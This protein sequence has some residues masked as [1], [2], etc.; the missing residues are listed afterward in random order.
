MRP[1]PVKCVSGDADDCDSR[2]MALVRL[3]LPST[4]PLE[5]RV[6]RNWK[7]ARISCLQFL[8]AESVLRKCSGPNVWTCSIQASSSCA[9]VSAVAVAY[10]ARNASL[11]CHACSSRGSCSPIRARSW[12]CFSVRSSF[13]RRKRDCLPSRSGF[14]SFLCAQL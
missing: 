12:A 3:F 6:G 13:A 14:P 8:K 5:M 11:S 2:I 10:Q 4:K 9:A 1:S 7:K